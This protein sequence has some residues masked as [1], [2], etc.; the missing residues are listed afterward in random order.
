MKRIKNIEAA[1]I[2]NCFLNC[3]KVLFIKPFLSLFIISITVF[4][5]HF[6]YQQNFNLDGNAKLWE[7]AFI[8][9]IAS[10]IILYYLVGFAYQHPELS[11]KGKRLSQALKYYNRKKKINT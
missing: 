5:L 2:Y 10:G 3:Y 8:F 4:G 7:Q 11:I 6:V 1:F 9:I